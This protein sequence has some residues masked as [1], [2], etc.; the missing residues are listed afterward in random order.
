MNG[1]TAAAQQWWRGAVIYQIYPRSFCDSNG[2]GVGDLPGITSKLDYVAQLGVDAIWI[3]PFFTSPMNDFGYDISD[4]RGVDP[5]FGTLQDFV[6]LIERAHELDLKVLIDQVLSHSSDQHAWF[7][8]S[9]VDRDN[10]KS[11]WYV[12]ADPKPDGSPPNNW[13]SVFGGV[14][15]TWEARRQQYYLHNFLTSQ[16]DLN[17]HNPDVRAAQLA[18]MRFWLELGVDGFRLDV[19][20][21]CYHHKDLPDNPPSNQAGGSAAVS[22]SNPYG[23]QEHRYDVSQP[24]N[25]EF[26]REL[27]SLLDEYP[28]TTTV[29][30]IGSSDPLGDMARYTSG[31]DKLHMAYTFD[32]LRGRSSADYLRQ[33]LNTVNA[34]LDDGWPCWSL[35]NHDVMRVC[36]RWGCDHAPEV[37]APVALALLLSLRGSVCLYQG[38]ELGLVEADVPFER[39]QDPFGKTFWPDFK[40]RDGC[41]TPM[42]WSD[43]KG[44][45]FTEDDIEPWL[46]IEPRHLPASV[47]CQEKQPASVLHQ[48]RG[49]IEWRRAQPAL[50]HGD[51]E[52]LQGTGDALSFVRRSE[53]Q[54]M[55]VAFNLTMNTVALDFSSLGLSG[56]LSQ[57]GLGFSF[58]G[59]IID[60]VISLGPCQA[61]FLEIA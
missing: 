10:E 17:F 13:L 32:L 49:L 59:Q 53:Q 9:K 11:D 16:P 61:V 20:N 27:R 48:L 37:F 5:L 30:E 2:D 56:S 38:D 18:N 39:L 28:G 3:S 7:A 51:L 40:G 47:A 23:W 26:L 24:E 29:G 54:A 58:S 15:W 6:A 21:Y 50:R 19:I 12:W 55:F 41:R 1:Q 45:G 4:Y 52:I 25:I 43:S 35:S 33:V 8:Q 60:D 31:G 42:V 46:P 22:A 44:A 34:T 14:A 36:S 57:V